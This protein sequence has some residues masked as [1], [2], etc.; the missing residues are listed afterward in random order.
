MLVAHVV[1]RNVPRVH[2]Q[3]DALSA[4]RQLLES[5][6]GF[7]PVIDEEEGGARVVGVFGYRDAFSATYGRAGRPTTLTV[8]A[9]MSPPVC[10]CCESDTFGQA[11]RKLRRSGM[12]ALPV[13]DGDGYL[14]GVLSFADLVHEAAF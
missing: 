13:L 4:A 1:N 6:F 12:D 2:P 10:T 9:A 3:D 14:V 7:L 8:G 5:R 11:V